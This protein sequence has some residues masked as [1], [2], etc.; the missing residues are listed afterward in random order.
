MFNRIC[1]ALLPLLFL[2]CFFEEKVR[3]DPNHIFSNQWYLRY[4][5]AAQ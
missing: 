2:N 3:I 1:C 5:P 4:A